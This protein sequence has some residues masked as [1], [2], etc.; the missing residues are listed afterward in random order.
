MC[1]TP[2]EEKLE[3]TEIKNQDGNRYYMTKCKFCEQEFGSETEMHLHWGEKH[4][5]EL[6]SHQKEK[7]K[8]AERSR[9]EQKK[10]KKRT[11]ERY[12]YTGIAVLA[13]LGL[14]T[15]AYIFMPSGALGGSGSIGPA[16]SSHHHAD[17]AVF[18]NGEKIDFSQRQYQVRDQRAHVEG[19]NGDVV[20]SHARG[21]TFSYF[22]QTLG[23]DYNATYMKTPDN[24]YFENETHQVRMFVNRGDGWEEVEPRQFMFT[25]GDR[26]LLVYGEY[27]ESEIQSMQNGVTQQTP[28]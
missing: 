26:I 25:G 27:T 3:R 9:E 14:A 4:G 28:L 24:E 1:G 6:N 13:V 7:V 17:F 11:Y 12:A 16:G 22:I 21:A 10:D 15:G 20:H 5:D 18:V 8:K 19:G 2:G 23:F